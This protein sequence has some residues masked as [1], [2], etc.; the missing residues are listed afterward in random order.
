MAEQHYVI[1]D[2]AAHV[3]DFLNLGWES[4]NS[5]VGTLSPEMFAD[6]QKYSS[7]KAVEK[8]INNKEMEHKVKMHMWLLVILAVAPFLSL[9]FGPAFPLAATAIGT[10]AGSLAGIFA[11]IDNRGSHYENILMKCF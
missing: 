11:G 6:I 2:G 9:F 4:V 7:V 8:Y 3:N 1:L 5:A 10:I